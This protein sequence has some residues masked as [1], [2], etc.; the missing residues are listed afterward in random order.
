[1][2]K[3]SIRFFLTVSLSIFSVSAIIYSLHCQY[4]PIYTHFS[5]SD[6][7]VQYFHSFIIISP[8]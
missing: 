3:S 1:M 2:S 4:E 7:S 5:H 6:L 8:C